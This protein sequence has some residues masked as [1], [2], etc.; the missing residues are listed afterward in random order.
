MCQDSIR[1][2]LQQDLKF[3]TYKMQV[4]KELKISDYEK[5]VNFAVIMQELLHHNP[6]AILSMSF[7][8]NGSVNKQN[9]CHWAPLN[10]CDV[11]EK[12]LHTLKVAVWSDSLACF[13]VLGHILEKICVT[14]S[15]N[16]M[17]KC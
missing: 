14:V 9:F 13:G 1:K 3:H 17:L 2:F 16:S 7:H 10:P 4:I 6:N 5:R 11:H 12:P 8:L 15:L